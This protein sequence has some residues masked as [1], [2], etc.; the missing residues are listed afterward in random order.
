M[1]I[2]HQITEAVIFVDL[3]VDRNSSLVAEL[4]AEVEVV[5]GDSVVCWFGPSSASVSLG[6][7]KAVQRRMECWEVTDQ[8]G[9]MSRSDAMIVKLLVTSL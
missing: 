1:R 6:L 2:E 4:S 8:A 9:R 5:E 3:C 7:F